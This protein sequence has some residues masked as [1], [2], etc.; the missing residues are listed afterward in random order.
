MFRL[1]YLG[2]VAV[3][4]VACGVS[5]AW[6]VSFSTTPVADALASSANAATNYGAAGAIAVSAAGLPKGEL[7][8]LL[9]FD[10]AAA[11]ASF[12]AALVGPWAITSASLQLTAAS[13]G[14]TLFNSPSAAGQIAAS[15]MQNDAWVEGT[16][17][18][19][20]PS[21]TG[22]TWNDLPTLVSGADQS[23]G[24][25]AFNGATSGTTIWTLTLASGLTGD[26]IV[27]GL[28]SIRLFA[29][30]GETTVSGVFN[31]RQ[32]GTA[33]SRPMLVLEAQAVPE[34]ASAALAG[35]CLVGVAATRRRLV[36]A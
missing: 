7:Q 10:L 5:S 11:K 18:P 4:V 8:S 19:M 34:P 31:V 15:W 30:A 24:T 16:G 3:A 6:A 1:S 26:A 2:L 22:V 14:N 25:F 33:A 36:K 28:A 12:D 17:T 35:A 32:F 9:R 20:L 27:G 29:P 21:A 23:L 13:P